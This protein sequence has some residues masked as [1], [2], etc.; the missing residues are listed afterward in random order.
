VNCVIFSSGKVN[1][2]FSI[3]EIDRETSSVNESHSWFSLLIN[4]GIRLLHLLIRILSLSLELHKLIE[5]KAFL[6]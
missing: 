6:H 4:L 5:F 1:V 3:R 2:F